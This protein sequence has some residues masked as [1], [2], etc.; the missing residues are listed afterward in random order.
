MQAKSTTYVLALFIVGYFFYALIPNA[1]AEDFYK[2]KSI[3]FV[4]GFSPGGGFDAY[5]RAIARHIGK[6]IPGDPAAI[7]ENMTGAG[8]L[9]AANFLYNR[10]KPDGLT[11]GHFHGG[12]ILSQ[13]LGRP[14]ISFEARKFKWIGAPARLEA[15]CAFSKR[16]GISTVDRW[17]SAKTPPKMGATAPGSQ[18]YD[19]PT[20][21]SAAANLPAQIV[22]G[23]KGAAEIRLAVESGEIDG[24]CEGWEAMSVSWRKL[25]E[26]GDAVVVIQSPSKPLPD[27][28]K[29]SL[30]IDLAKTKEARSIIQFGI[31]DIS[32]IL[33]P[34]AVPPGTPNEQVIILRKAFSATMQDPEFLNEMKKARLTVDPM[35][36]EELEKTIES[37]FKLE[38]TVLTKFKEILVP[39]KQ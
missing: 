20:I 13:V 5:T 22:S 23:Y 39:K 35:S 27:L 26:A 28:P 37:F 6:H 10:T 33:R 1:R 12:L 18:T 17:A 11:I 9:V 4:L 24:S 36:G 3:R 21:L 8:S 14:G 25:F 15:V 34:Y 16:S 29:V 32:D 38:P 30:A 7:V 19:M 31:Q 2:G